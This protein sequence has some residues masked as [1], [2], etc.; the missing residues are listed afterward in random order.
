[1]TDAPEIPL[2]DRNFLH[3][4]FVFTLPWLA[5]VIILGGS[6]AGVNG[7]AA[8]RVFDAPIGI[9]LNA[10]Y[11]AAPFALMASAMRPRPRVSRALWAGAILTATIW[12]LYAFAGRKAENGEVILP[13]NYVA[14]LE[15]V[16]PQSGE[17]FLIDA[18]EISAQCAQRGWRLTEIWNTHH[19]WDH[20]GGNAALKEKHRLEIYGPNMIAGRIPELDNAVGEGDA[21]KFGEH[22]VQ[23]MHTPGHTTDHIIYY[24][25]DAYDGKGAAFVGDTIFALGCGRLFEGSPED[26]HASLSKIMALPDSTALYCAHEYTLSN[27]KFALH[28]EPDNADLIA[29]MQSAEAKRDKGLAT[30]PTY[31]AA[32]RM[33]NPFITAGNAQEL[34]RRRALKDNF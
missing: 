2:K 8:R 1:M 22:V 13:H 28:V 3:A 32:E 34:G 24:V 17:L 5:D 20:T 14:P 30:V 11:A 26:M 31:V 18:A 21:F 6:H 29:A 16:T 9:M 25:A 4:I 7:E 23:V 19:H 27:G 15:Y 33:T 12:A 10:V